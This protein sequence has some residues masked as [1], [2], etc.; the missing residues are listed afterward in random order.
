ML[1][2]DLS[3]LSDFFERISLFTTE[4]SER[5]PL[6]EPLEEIT[7]VKTGVDTTGVTGD[8]LIKT[9]SVE[10]NDFIS[11]P[12]FKPSDLTMNDS[13]DVISIVSFLS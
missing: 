3:V 11:V 13:S 2:S 7:G 9:C 10:V 1:L 8:P 12:Y 4:G 6:K 5:E